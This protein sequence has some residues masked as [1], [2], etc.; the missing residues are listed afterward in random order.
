[1]ASKVIWFSSFHKL[2]IINLFVFITVITENF[3]TPFVAQSY[4]RGK[5]FWHVQAQYTNTYEPT[6]PHLPVSASTKQYLYYDYNDLVVG[7]SNTIT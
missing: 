1:M 5:G 4:G 2:S 6:S 3:E 7:M